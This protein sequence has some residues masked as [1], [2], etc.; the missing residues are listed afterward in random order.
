MRACAAVNG[1]GGRAPT[2]RLVA[3]VALSLAAC[4]T[5]RQGVPFIV[6]MDAGFAE[7]EAGAPVDATVAD[8]ADSAVDS[9][10]DALSAEAAA[11]A[12]AADPVCCT[13][14]TM[15][16]PYHCAPGIVMGDLT[17]LRIAAGAS[18]G[19]ALLGGIGCAHLCLPTLRGYGEPPDAGEC[20][21]LGACCP[22]IPGLNANGCS[23]IA[24]EWNEISCAQAIGYFQA[25]GFCLVP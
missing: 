24:D 4:G 15:A 7:P 20:A 21:T 13:S 8:V 22:T 25:Q 23:F 18:N 17:L 14:P 16:P 12:C 10:L 5:I 3:A 6:P 9:P 1:V 2:R 19:G 11:A